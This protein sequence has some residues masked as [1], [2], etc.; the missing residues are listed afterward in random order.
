MDERIELRRPAP[1]SRRFRLTPLARTSAEADEPRSTGSSRRKLI[2]GGAAIPVVMTVRGRPAFA[3][4]SACTMSVMLSA[5]NSSPLGG[6]QTGELG[7]CGM[8]PNG[9]SDTWEQD[10]TTLNNDY[11]T[12]K[13]TYKQ[14]FPAQVTSN[15]YLG[16][17]AITTSFPFTVPSSAYGVSFTITNGHN[18]T[19]ALTDGVALT[20]KVTIGSKNSSQ[21]DSGQFFAQAIAAVLNSALYGSSAFG[22]T[23]SQ[24]IKYINGVFTSMQ[25][26]ADSMQITNPNVTPSEILASIFSSTGPV[27]N[28]T[29]VT[30][31]LSTLNNQGG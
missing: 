25:T 10:Y 13:Y 22:Y 15:N 28:G 17:P 9:A 3:Q 6:G 27:I 31:E 7:P 5:R 11:T 16:N 24:M 29:N 1:A 12:G 8:P 23:D 26:Q 20:V 2:V 4:P 30:S 21:S 19:S 18:L 14:C